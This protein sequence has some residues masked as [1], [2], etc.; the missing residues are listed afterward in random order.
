M[1]NL[2]KKDNM[3]RRPRESRGNRD[4]FRKREDDFDSKVLD[5]SRVVR[6]TSGGRRMKFRA[7]V[8]VGD[9]KGKV[10]LGISKGIDVAQAINKATR[11]AKKNII[12]VVMTEDTIPHEV[13]AKFGAARISLKPQKKGR[14]LVAGGALRSICELVGIKNIS[15]K[16]L[17]K[18]KNMINNTQATL[19]ALK[20]LKIQKPKEYA[21]KS[22]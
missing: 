12:S 6:M 14:G 15:G 5:L 21:A 1:D 22:N 13:E 20:K 11:M 4:S 19:K 7:V 10:G 17:S 18:T 3:D 8:A 9:K 16:R 2:N